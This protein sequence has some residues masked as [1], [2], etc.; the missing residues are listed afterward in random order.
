MANDFSRI[1]FK[2]GSDEDLKR[3]Y[4]EC[5]SQ[6]DRTETVEGTAEVLCPDD[7]AELW[8]Y[9]LPGEEVQPALC[10][11]SL[12]TK[13][14][15]KVRS[16]GLFRCKESPN[17]VR[18]LMFR[19][20][21]GEFKLPMLLLNHLENPLRGE[22]PCQA[23]PVLFAQTLQVYADREDFLANQPGNTDCP[24]VIPWMDLARRDVREPMARMTGLTEN[25]ELRVNPL[26]GLAY[27]VL[28]MNCF[29][30]RFPVA[31]DFDQ[32]DR[33]LPKPGSVLSGTFWICGTA[34][35]KETE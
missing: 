24:S 14:S 27:A 16:N 20:Y 28:T 32:L 33:M 17:P 12:R 22:G 21:R 10:E 1:G 6:L 4:S 7:M 15:H 8:F 13:V 18:E 19:S 3:L 35:G 26:T 11:P 2:V 30:F 25:S 29:G 34:S 5:G 9:G 31:A 23:K